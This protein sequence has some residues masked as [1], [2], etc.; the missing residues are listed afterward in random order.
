MHASWTQWKNLFSFEVFGQDGYLIV[1]G[2]GGS[3]GLE[4][5]RVGRRKVEGGAP[6]EEV[7]EFSSPDISWEAEWREFVAAIQEYR[8]PLANGHD[9]WQAMRMVY[10][11]Y[12]SART[13]QVVRLEDGEK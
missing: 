12:E 3:Y 13:G 6:E 2:L 8:E 9:G 5:L 11:I 10:A 7:L 1:E 4:R